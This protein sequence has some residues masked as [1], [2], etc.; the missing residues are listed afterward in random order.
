MNTEPR[1]PPVRLSSLLK[2]PAFIL[3]RAQH[4]QNVLVPQR[5]PLTLREPT[6]SRAGLASP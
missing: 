2:K 5:V 1:H 3:R 4:E 6:G